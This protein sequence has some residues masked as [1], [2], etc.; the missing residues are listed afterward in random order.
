MNRTLAM[1]LLLGLFILGFPGESRSSIESTIR[2]SLSK[3]FN[4]AHFSVFSYLPGS[5]EARRFY[6]GRD[7]EEV[8]EELSRDACYYTPTGNGVLS[9]EEL[10]SLQREAVLKF[11]L[12]PSQF[13]FF[14]R[15]L[16][17]RQL[18]TTANVLVKYLHG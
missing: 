13:T 4:L 9:G 3:P 6:E 18:A 2:Y 11:Y 15:R 7:P 14:A 5:E 17:M 1:A 8:I 16:R 12:R 10:K